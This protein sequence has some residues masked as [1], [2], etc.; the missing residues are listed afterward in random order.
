MEVTG[1]TYHCQF[2]LKVEHISELETC[3]RFGG[4]KVNGHV[5]HEVEIVANSTAFVNSFDQVLTCQ[6]K[7]RFA[8]LSSNSPFRTLFKQDHT[9]SDH[10]R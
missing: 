8:R 4:T 3:G 6:R 2:P 1:H 9:V 7:V 5:D 10:L